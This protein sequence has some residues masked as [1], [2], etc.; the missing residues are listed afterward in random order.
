MI[1][2]SRVTNAHHRRP[3]ITRLGSS[4]NY[5]ELDLSTENLGH[6]GCKDTCGSGTEMDV[7]DCF[8]QFELASWFGIDCPRTVK[9]WRDHGFDVTGVYE[10]E[11][12]RNISVQEHDVLFPVINVMPTG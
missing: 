12:A 6:L 8:Y 7:S 3:P 11:I 1:I 5:A 4:I 10:E 9:F 2:D